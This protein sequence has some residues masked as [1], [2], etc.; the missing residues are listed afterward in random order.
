MDPRV[1]RVA[2][3]FGAAVAGA[4][5]CAVVALA[6]GYAGHQPQPRDVRIAVAAPP[7]VQRQVANALQRAAPGFTATSTGARGAIAAVRD[8]DSDGALV[9][10]GHARPKIVTA[11]ASGLTQQ[12]AIDAV[13]GAI[14]SRLGHPGQRVDIAPLPAGDRGGQSSFVFELALLVPSVLGAVGLFLAGARLRLWWRVAAGLVFAA[15]AAAAAVLVLDPLLGALTGAPLGLLGFGTFGALTCVLVA[16][17]LQ[18]VFG[19]AGTG[20][21]ALV[22]LFVGNAMS[23]G[24]VPRSFLPAGFR[25]ISGWLP[26][27]AI[28]RLTRATVYFGTD[29]VGHPLLVLAIW[30][31]AALAT[32]AAVD[33]RRRPPTPEINAAAEIVDTPP[34]NR[35]GGDRDVQG[36]QRRSGRSLR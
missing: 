14:T 29:G 9:L 36:S 1:R 3:L 22:F 30:S 25:Q 16:L 13:L 33:A 8:Q 5:I 18:A 31:G 28:V 15:L 23:G 21:A 17:A 12:Q 6:Y 26:N 34:A 11:G 27:L 24:T 19:L 10:A 2:P 35:V 4:V 32:I 20:I 7:A